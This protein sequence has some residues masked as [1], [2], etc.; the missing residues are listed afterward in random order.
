MKTV[1]TLLLLLSSLAS[2][3]GSYDP[4]VRSVEWGLFTLLVG[5]AFGF[6]LGYLIGRTPESKDQHQPDRDPPP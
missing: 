6:V 5:A 2:M 4:W 1:V 3:A